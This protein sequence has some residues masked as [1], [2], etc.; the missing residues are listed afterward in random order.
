MTPCPQ[1][2][3]LKSG[4]CWGSRAASLLCAERCTNPLWRTFL[5]QIFPIKGCRWRS[6]RQSKGKSIIDLPVVKGYSDFHIS[7]VF[8]T[9]LFSP[10]K[11]PNRHIIHACSG[12]LLLLACPALSEPVTLLTPLDLSPRD[13]R[14]R[15]HFFLRPL[16]ARLPQY[17]ATQYQSHL[18]HY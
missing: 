1:T 18:I 2:W 4:Q 7:L 8:I 17:R 9:K 13:F 3:V 11:L 14:D 15:M 5:P 6:E 16:A 10:E 12:P